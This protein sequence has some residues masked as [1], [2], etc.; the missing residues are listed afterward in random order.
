MY[1]AERGRDHITS[2]CSAK[3]RE[4]DKPSTHDGLTQLSSDADK[5]TQEAQSLDA[6]HVVEVDE[7]A[8][9]EAAYEKSQQRDIR[10]KGRPVH[11]RKPRV[12]YVKMRRRERA[13]VVVL[14]SEE[15]YCY[16][17]AG[18]EPI[19]EHLAGLSSPAFYTALKQWKTT[20]QLGMRGAGSGLSDA[21]TCPDD[22]AV[23]DDLNNLTECEISSDMDPSDLIETMDMMQAMEETEHMQTISSAETSP[24]KYLLA[25]EAKP[26]PKFYPTKPVVN[27]TARINTI[28]KPQK[29]AAISLP[30]TGVPTLTRVLVWARNTRDRY[31]VWEILAGY[32]IIMEDDFIGSR[33]ARCHRDFVRCDEYDYNFVIPQHLVTKLDAVVESEKR[34]RSK[35]KYFASGSE[36]TH[37]EGTTEEIIAGAVYRMKEFYNIRKKFAALCADVEWLQ[38]TK[39]EDISA[40]PELFNEETDSDDLTP[41]TAGQKHRDLAS[42]VVKVFDGVCL[43]S[44]F[45]LTTGESALKVDN[46]VGMLARDQML[47]DLMIDFSI[48][49]ICST[50]GDC[51][52]LDSFAPDLGSPPPPTTPISSFHYVVMPVH[53][54]GIHWGII[55]VRIA[56]M[57][58]NPSITPYY[59]EPL[60]GS[61]YRATMEDIYNKTVVTF[62]R[63]WHRSTLPMTEY[64]VEKNGVWLNAPK[65]P[66][67]TSCGVLCIAQVYSILKDSFSLANAIVTQDDVAVMRLR[68]MWMIMMQPDMT[69][70]HNKLAHDVEATDLELLATIEI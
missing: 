55:I 10:Q 32:P 17:K 61:S 54:N 7:H 15:K 69:T 49:C 41:S 66:D 67:G 48:R 36:V 64:P 65:Q 47:S 27:L 45:R 39:W 40:T 46:L 34:K 43:G 12:I 11:R 70:R 18:F 44:Q 63:D 20:V 57:L 8:T 53:L 5:N 68:I 51:Y 59:Y 21:T 4:A 23:S 14:S 30:G 35:P 50:L 25:K 56:Y 28:P 22:S 60:C 26:K 3:R 38:S 9:Y 19:M 31:H 29:L 37:P 16:A 33:A 2:G 6:T 62:L 58:Q 52:A 24:S 13:N 42:E 1:I